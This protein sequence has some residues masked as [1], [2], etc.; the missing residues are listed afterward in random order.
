MPDYK[1]RRQRLLDALGDG[2]LLIPTSRPVIRNGDVHFSFRAGSDFHYLTG[3]EEP[4]ALLVAW[5]T[6]KGRHRAVLF[7]Q[8]RDKA[9]EIWDGR[10]HGVAGA[11]RRF[12]ADEAYPIDALRKELPRLLG[13]HG[14]L[15]HTLGTNASLDG[16]LSEVF[17]ERRAARRRRNPSAHPVIEDPLPKLASMRLIK[18]ED[19]LDVMR[20]A[21][22]IS[23]A[24]HVAAM[25]A[26]RPGMSE[27]QV[28]AVV[29]QVFRDRGSKRN[30]YDSIVAS[31]PNACILHYIENTRKIRRGDLLLLDAGAEVDHYTADITRTWP[32][33][34][35]FSAAQRAV[36]NVVLRAQK[37]CVR[38]V[39]PGRAVDVVHKTAVREITKG[40]LEIGLLRGE[41]ATLIEKGACRKWFMHGTSHWLGMDVHD[42]GA[43]E[44][45]RGRPIKF[46]PGM[47]LTVEPGL[48]F[49]RADKS[50]PAA[51]RGVGVR[52]EDDIAVTAAGN[53][54]LT[55]EVPKDVGEIER[56]CGVA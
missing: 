3:F 33:G 32:V 35:P 10:R 23:A 46:T 14:R 47:V 36:Y 12:G 31:G 37:A 5:R 48:Y 11:K 45:E 52:I 34:A 17:T 22:E 49:D 7:V 25:R 9:R 8:P 1:A 53:E 41:L 16:L 13:D 55:D 19:E 18:D 38:A 26:A 54:N 42:V 20:R 21:G 29:E 15:F 40:L 27:Q 2:L 39:K 43:Y 4:H 28:Q 51:F 44:D 30:G 24:A 56:L 6:G 50:V